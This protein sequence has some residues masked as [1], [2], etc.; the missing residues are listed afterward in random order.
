[1]E[2]EERGLYRGGVGGCRGVKFEIWFYVIEFRIRFGYKDIK[3]E[4]GKCDNKYIG[5]L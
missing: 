3:K 1:M 4:Y 5:E 2:W